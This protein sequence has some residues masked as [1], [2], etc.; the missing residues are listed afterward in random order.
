MQEVL[1]ITGPCGVGK[2]T[3]AIE[4]AK[5]KNGAVIECDFL[6][7]WI[8]NENFPHWSPEEEKFTSTLASKMVLEYLNYDMPVAIENVWTPFG[9]EN[10]IKQLSGS[11]IS[12]IRVIRLIC[13]IKENHRRDQ[14]RIPADQM[15]ER[16][17]IVNDQLNAIKWPK[18][19]NLIDNTNLSLKD[20]LH[21]IERSEPIT[22]E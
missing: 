22:V 10:I 1:I 5:Q 20:V 18:Y 9:I 15:K 16:V 6:T 11:G 14:N 7:E 12:K 8:Y 19:V 17:D 21:Q 4:W 3:T 2:T 13:N